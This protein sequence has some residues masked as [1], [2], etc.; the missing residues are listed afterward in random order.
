MVED[1]KVRGR[2]MNGNVPDGTINEYL[3]NYVKLYETKVSEDRKA[4]CAEAQSNLHNFVA[5]ISQPVA[6]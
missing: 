3:A 1:Y 2:M 6:K 4:F 5:N